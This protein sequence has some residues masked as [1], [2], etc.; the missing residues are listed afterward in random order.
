VDE[1][2]YCSPKCERY[3]WNPKKNKWETKHRYS[4]PTVHKLGVAGLLDKYKKK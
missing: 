3:Y 4:E 1:R 2:V